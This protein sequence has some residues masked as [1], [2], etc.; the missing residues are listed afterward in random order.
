MNDFD[1]LNDDVL[2]IIFEFIPPSVKF[3]LNKQLYKINER[4]IP[5]L[6]TFL[7]NIIR[8]DYPF[9]FEYYLVN[10]YK[11]WRKITRW[12]YKNMIFHNYVEYSRYLCIIYESSKCKK[13]L[14][15]HEKKI[16]PQRKKKYKRIGIRSTRW[17][18]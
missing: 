1:I 12:I 8:L 9:V 16:N 4:K 5:K 11:K 17:S 18:N 7:R 14:L 13:I 10:K 3:S 6:D 15:T 2:N